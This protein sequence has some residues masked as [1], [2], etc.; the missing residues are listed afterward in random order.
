MPPK[1][2][3]SSWVMNETN[4]YI[5]YKILYKLL[6]LNLNLHKIITKSTF[7]TYPILCIIGCLLFWNKEN[8]SYEINMNISNYVT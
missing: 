4:E 8:Q 7:E 3:V 2:E 1:I 6:Y 5:W